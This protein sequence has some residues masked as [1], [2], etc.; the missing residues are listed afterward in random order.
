MLHRLHHLLRGGDP[1]PADGTFPP[2]FLLDSVA[3]PPFVQ[4]AITKGMA[5][6]QVQRVLRL[7]EAYPARRFSDDGSIHGDND[8]VRIVWPIRE[9]WPQWP[10]EG[11]TQKASKKRRRGDGDAC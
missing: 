4:A 10:C 7:L 5:A 8:I 2:H 6:G 9:Q 1:G 11:H 3:R